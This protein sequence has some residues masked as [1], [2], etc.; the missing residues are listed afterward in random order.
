MCRVQ[1]SQG[2]LA[3]SRDQMRRNQETRG[4]D[5]ARVVGIFSLKTCIRLR[6]RFEFGI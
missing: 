5:V 6:A 3:I 4:G 1:Q 2:D